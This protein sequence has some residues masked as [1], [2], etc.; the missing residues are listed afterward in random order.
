MFMSLL[1]KK[2]YKELFHATNYKFTL[3]FTWIYH[4]HSHEASST[5]FNQKLFIKLILSWSVMTIHH[6]MCDFVFLSDII[7]GGHVSWLSG[8]DPEVECRC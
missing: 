4:A 2:N 7:E 3:K 1:P 5:S 6:P 8:V